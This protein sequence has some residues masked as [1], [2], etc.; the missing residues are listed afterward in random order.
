MRVT[1]M[2]DA[3]Y[4]LAQSLPPCQHMGYCE[5]EVKLV[6]T[7]IRGPDVDAKRAAH[8]RRLPNRSAT[9]TTAR[10]PHL[11]VRPASEGPPSS[12]PALGPH[13]PTQRFYIM[14]DRLIPSVGLALSLHA[15]PP[16]GPPLESAEIQTH[17]VWPHHPL[18]I[19][20]YA[21]PVQDQ[22]LSIRIR[23]APRIDAWA[24]FL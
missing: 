7:S 19:R 11:P 10:N 13:P 15:P 2:R 22:E 21:V 1:S 12:C 9:P 17:S 5:T 4:N 23:I 3:G 16:L 14:R 6:E 8:C 20:E 24:S 18:G